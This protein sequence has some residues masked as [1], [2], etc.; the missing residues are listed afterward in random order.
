MNPARRNSITLTAAL[1]LGVA[2]GLAGLRGKKPASEVLPSSAAVSVPAAPAAGHDSSGDGSASSS[3][4]RTAEV[5]PPDAYAAAWELLQQRDLRRSERQELESALV[6][7]WSKIDLRA[8]LH[9]QF[10]VEPNGDVDDPFQLSP[11]GA[12]REEVGR[13]PDLVWELISSREYGLQTR[14]LRAEWIDSC[15]GRKPLEVLRRLR[16]LPAEDRAEAIEMAIYY[17]HRRSQPAPGKDEVVT[18]VLALRGTPDEAAALEG[19]AMG[20]ARV[21]ETSELGTLLLDPPAPE[22]REVYL[23]AYAEA[24]D[25]GGALSENPHLDSLPPDLRAEVE[26]VMKARRA[27]R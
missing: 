4:I 23:M 8:A 10:S 21:T 22:L 18:A 14:L 6:A 11:V 12:C 2:L 7:E 17:T 3:S 25:G 5:S 27:E 20:L 19:F 16:D 1:L 24:I 26:A 13:Q 15:A 9:A